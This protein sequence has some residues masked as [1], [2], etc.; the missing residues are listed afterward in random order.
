MPVH[1]EKEV[2]YRSSIS[3]RWRLASESVKCLITL[4]TKHTQLPVYIMNVRVE[5]RLALLIA[6]LQDKE[7]ALDTALPCRN[8]TPACEQCSY[9]KI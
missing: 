7:F 3:S 8:K 2:E 4:E 1:S 6:K 9:G 5:P